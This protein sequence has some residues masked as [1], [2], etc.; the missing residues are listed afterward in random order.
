[1]KC[2]SCGKNIPNKAIEGA[3]FIKDDKDNWWCIDCAKR[4]LTRWPE[5]EQYEKLAENGSRYREALTKV[6]T[7]NVTPDFR[8]ETSCMKPRERCSASAEKCLRCWL[9]HLVGEEMEG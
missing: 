8:G 2:F 4:C 7:E 9:L 1:M 6:L 3:E 5:F